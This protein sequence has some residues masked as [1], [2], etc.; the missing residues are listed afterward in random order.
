MNKE[1]ARQRIAALSAELH[2]H[3]H[4]YYVLNQPEISDFD[5]DMKLKELQKLEQEFPELVT[6]DSPTRRVGSDV[7]QKFEQVRHSIPMLSLDNTYNEQEIADF[8]AR[9][10]KSADTPFEYVCELKYDGVA[11]ALTY[12]KGILTRAVT[13]GDGDQG[14]NVTENVKTIA[15]I[16]LRLRGEQIPDRYEIRGEIIMPHRAFEKLNQEREKEGKPVFANPRN[17]AAGSLKMQ[18]S[19]EVARR[20]LDCFLYQPVGDGVTGNSHTESL[21]QAARLG[22][23]TSAYIR[24]CGNLEEIFDFIN[25][26]D[27]ERRKLPYD[28]DGVVI[29][30]NNYSLRE[31]LGFTAKS[32]RWAIAYKF[33][34]EQA[35]TL[36]LD[37]AFQVGRTG[38]V[39]PVAILEPVQ[40]A[41]TTVKRASLHNEDIIK[42]LG[43]R[44]NDLVKVEKGGEIIPKVVGV[45]SH[46]DRNRN[47]AI[48]FIKKCPECGTPLIKNPDEAAH[49]CPNEKGCPPQIKGKLVHFISRKAMNIDSLGEGKIEILYDAGLVKNAA[50]I[51]DLTF[52]QVFGL[53]KTYREGDKTRIVKFQEKTTKNIL[54]GIEQSKQVPF[55]RVLYALGIRF[56]GETVAKKLARYFKNIEAL[57]V[58]SYEDLIEIDEIGDR[59]AGSIREYFST[60][61]YQQLIERLRKHG[62]RFKVDQNSAEINSGVLSNKRIVVSGVFQRFSRDEIKRII[63]Q[64][65]GRNVSSVSAKTDYL[66]AGENMGPRKKEKA[67][68]LGVK[69]ITEN[70]F[71]KLTGHS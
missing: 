13:R 17:S 12:E 47:A 71:L 70:E 69:V 39:T 35:V 15:S 59:I 49:Y 23:K 33:K 45:K 2:H 50:D 10:R 63:E 14:D 57:M 3:N 26:W 64:H 29:K 37:V 30:V 20:S 65:G 24:R 60:P 28:I 21:K 44:K 31:K 52:E 62:L 55:E 4:A 58:A 46:A 43:L 22:L 11:I 61:D 66:V 48:T 32:P 1:E 27:E 6:P 51:Y 5:F 9:V 38:A 56:V 25:H 40:L 53:Q 8:D 54:Q 68:S 7:D 42:K 36:L 41:G 19:A 18:K 16:P 34:A 67:K